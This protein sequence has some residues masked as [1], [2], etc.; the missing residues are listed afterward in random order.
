[1]LDK[2]DAPGRLA[3]LGER[4]LDKLE[5]TGSS[6]VAPIVHG[7]APSR[8]RPRQ[9]HVTTAN[10]STR[11]ATC[12]CQ[13]RRSSAPPCTRTSRGPLPTRSWE[14]SSPSPELP[15]SPQPTRTSG[16]ARVL[17]GPRR[18][19]GAVAQWRNRNRSRAA[20]FV[21]IRSG[22]YSCRLAASSA[23]FG[24]RNNLV[25]AL[26]PTPRMVTHPFGIQKAYARRS[27]CH[28]AP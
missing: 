3:Q 10:S 13:A 20:R 27:R 4:Q 22:G 5:V 6:P 8:V 12:G 11:A 28:H 18:T 1:V 21:Q 14:T 15:P 23:S 26:F 16:V 9:S 25:R 17:N 19:G 7:F 2:L 24:S